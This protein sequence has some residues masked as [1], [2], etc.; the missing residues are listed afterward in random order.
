MTRRYVARRTGKRDLAF[1]GILVADGR[2]GC[3]LDGD[4][5]RRHTIR[6]WR[7]RVASEEVDSYVVEAGYESAWDH[8]LTAYEALLCDSASQ[9]TDF[10]LE[11]QPLGF[12]GYPDGEQFARKQARLQADLEAAY[13]ALCTQV[14]NEA[15][16]PEE[17]R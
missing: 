12:R 16:G 13:K 15:F 4:K 2:Q 5:H 6:I 10:L 9:V 17:I 7:V 14:L 11:R 1:D 8:E 3:P